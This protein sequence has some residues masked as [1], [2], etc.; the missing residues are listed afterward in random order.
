MHL[1]DAAEIHWGFTEPIEV[2][3]PMLE[4]SEEELEHIPLGGRLS[5][6]LLISFRGDA[7]RLFLAPTP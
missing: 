6:G 3:T 7:M 2:T 4:F 1:Q 5:Q